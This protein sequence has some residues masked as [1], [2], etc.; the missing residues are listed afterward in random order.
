L[1]YIT[2]IIN[3]CAVLT[4]FWEDS[5]SDDPNPV[6]L[7]ITDNISAKNWT[8]HISKKSIIGQALARFFC[9]LLINSRVGINA[10]WISTLENKIADAISR[11]KVT[12]LLRSPTSTY[13][14]SQLK[15]DHKEL[16]AYHFFHPSPKLLS[17]I[18]KI[19]LTQK[20]PL[21]SKVLEM[22]PPALGRLST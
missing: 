7:C 9:G 18:W 2:I 21:L 6:I 3:Y 8:I 5:I 17:V 14:F 16:K 1:E 4:A 11:L 15:Q 10:K 12:N 20:C 19:L 22:R 13:D